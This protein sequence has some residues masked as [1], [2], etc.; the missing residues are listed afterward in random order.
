[1]RI[2]AADGVSSRAL[3]RQGRRAGSSLTCAF[4][5]VVDRRNGLRVLTGFLTGFVTSF[6]AIGGRLP[7]PLCAVLQQQLSSF[8]LERAGRL[9]FR[10]FSMC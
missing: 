8:G 9:A 5:V 1:M 6:V 10:L 3:R 4:P 7:T 2:G